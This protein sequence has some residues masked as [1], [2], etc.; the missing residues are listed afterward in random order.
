MKGHRLQTSDRGAG[1]IHRWAPTCSCGGWTGH[2]RRTR[3]DAAGDWRTLHLAPLERVASGR[4]RSRRRA[5]G[6]LAPRPLTPTDQLPDELR[7]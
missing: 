7:A 1:H 5:R 3:D 4:L 6:P 2:F